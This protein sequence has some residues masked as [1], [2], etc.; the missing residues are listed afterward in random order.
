MT[1]KKGCEF[2]GIGQ[3]ANAK[4]VSGAFIY[5]NCREKQAFISIYL[6]IV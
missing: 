6:I 1:E 2:L 3:L 4:I 5:L